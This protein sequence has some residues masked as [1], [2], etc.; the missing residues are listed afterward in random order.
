M[1]PL[2]K[3]DLSW[4]LDSGGGHLTLSLASLPVVKI[5]SDSPMWA[6]WRKANVMMKNDDR[7]QDASRT[8]SLSLLSAMPERE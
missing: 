1:F 7:L 2:I 8:N 4:C 6:H 5:I 3:T